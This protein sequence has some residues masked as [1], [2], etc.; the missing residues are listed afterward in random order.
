MRTPDEANDTP[1]VADPE[2]RVE[3]DVVGEARWPMA[4]AVL[5]RAVNEFT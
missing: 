5:A 4:G 3:D 1:S 2:R